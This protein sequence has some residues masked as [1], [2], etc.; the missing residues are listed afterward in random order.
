MRLLDKLDLTRTISEERP[1][2]FPQ[3]IKPISDKSEAISNEYKEHTA[4]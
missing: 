3:E 2:A 4:P 1:A